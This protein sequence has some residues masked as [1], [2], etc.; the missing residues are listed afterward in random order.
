M[1]YGT[2]AL[3]I[4]LRLRTRRERSDRSHSSTARLALI[5][6]VLAALAGF[7]GA[8]VRADGLPWFA[9]VPVAVGRELAVVPAPRPRARE[10][11]R[12]ADALW[13]IHTQ[14]EQSVARVG[15]GAAF[16]QI[17]EIDRI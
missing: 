2:P 4:G 10:E 15:L 17:Q 1:A 3:G 13:S 16:Y 8:S 7:L 14:V 12:Y 9:A 6:A 5:A 11:Q